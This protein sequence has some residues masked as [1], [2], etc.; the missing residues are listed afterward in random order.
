MVEQREYADKA[1]PENLL[2]SKLMDKEVQQVIKKLPEE[3]RTAIVR[4]RFVE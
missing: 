1:S 3:Y 4:I 2:F